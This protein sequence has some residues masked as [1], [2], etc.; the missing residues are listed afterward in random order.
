[1]IDEPGPY[2]RILL[3]NE[4]EQFVSHLPRLYRH[5][6]PVR[7]MAWLAM[8]FGLKQLTIIIE[9]NHLLSQYV[10]II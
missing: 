9:H 2:R 8:A 4:Q 10:K 5:C 1:M 6:I 3:L 7:K